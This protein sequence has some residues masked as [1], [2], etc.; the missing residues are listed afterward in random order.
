MARS[1]WFFYRNTFANLFIIVKVIAERLAIEKFFRVSRVIIMP[2]R[3]ANIIFVGTGGYCETK[4][5]RRCSTITLM[6]DASI[7]G[8]DVA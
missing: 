1:L 4:G 5:V 7:I 8:G 3:I 2:F 6:Q